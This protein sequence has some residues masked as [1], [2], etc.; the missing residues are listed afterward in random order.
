M[1][2]QDPTVRKAGGEHEE[3]RSTTLLAPTPAR[4]LS[5]PFSVETATAESLYKRLY[6]EPASKDSW[7]RVRSELRPDGMVDL[8]QV[9]DVS[10]LETVEG[11]DI[12]NALMATSTPRVNRSFPAEGLQTA[13]EE[14]EQN[15]LRRRRAA[16]RKKYSVQQMTERWEVEAEHFM[17]KVGVASPHTP[18]NLKTT[19][20]VSLERRSARLNSVSTPDFEQQMRLEIEKEDG[21]EA[22]TTEAIFSHMR[23]I[24]DIT[25]RYFFLWFLAATLLLCTVVV[26]APYMRRLLE[27]PVAYCDSD[28]SLADS[29]IRAIDAFS[30]FNQATALQPFVVVTAM[31][32]R[33]SC[34]PCPLYGNCLNGELISCSPPYEIHHG[35]CVENPDVSHD[36]ARIADGIEQ[37]VISRVAASACQN[38]TV[39]NYFAGEDDVDAFDLATPIKVL[40]SELREFVASTIHY[41]SA[42]LDLPRDYVFHRA[43][44][45]ALRNLREIFVG[46]E[47][48]RIYAGTALAPWKCQAKHQLYS[49]VPVITVALLVSTFVGFLYR[50]YV[51]SRN[52]KQLIDRLYKEARF[53]LLRRADKPNRCFPADHLRENLFDTYAVPPGERQRMRKSVWPK[54][55]ALLDE[56]SR[57]RSQQVK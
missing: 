55:I 3:S 8:T 53:F 11:D 24:K 52:R 43:L 6:G 17:D 34:Q 49:H 44:D 56:D 32:E 38:V 4:A 27:K 35:V 20:P 9:E 39:W 30:S 50:R 26:S 46:D 18:I 51:I 37:Y 16:L 45:M 54:V 21:S 48:D 42:V 57:V 19:A 2:E 47:P 25:W 1:R 36:L 33:P 28:W 40:I 13:S 23:H 7:D 5:P 15:F 31:V 14:R 41:G 29:E 22:E 12:F 10:S